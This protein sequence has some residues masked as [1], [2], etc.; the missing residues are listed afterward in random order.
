MSAMI[1]NSPRLFGETLVPL[2]KANEHFPD[3]RSRQT[4]ERWMRPPGCRGT[5]LES[6]LIGSRRYLSKEGI[7]R[8]LA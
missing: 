7:A 8:F 4:Y 1:K 5:I 2:E 6:T 3:K